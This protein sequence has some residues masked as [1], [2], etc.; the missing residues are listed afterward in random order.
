MYIFRAV[1]FGPA[2]AQHIG[3]PRR[4]W[5]VQGPNLNDFQSYTPRALTSIKGE[6]QRCAPAGRIARGWK[7]PSHTWQIGWDASSRSMP[8]SSSH[9]ATAHFAAHAQ[10]IT[11]SIHG[12]SAPFVTPYSCAEHGQRTCPNPLI[13]QNL[14][15]TLRSETYKEICLGHVRSTA[16]PRMQPQYSHSHA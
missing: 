11:V 12:P 15:S 2:K 10:H 5:A 7:R 8:R 13:M 14:I 3:S 16:V 6:E 9:T 1:P 4:G